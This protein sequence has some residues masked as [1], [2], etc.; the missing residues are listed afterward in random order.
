MDGWI[1]GWIAV[2]M[3]GWP[4]ECMMDGWIDV[5]VGWLDGFVGCMV[6]WFCWI[7]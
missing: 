2:C 3:D 4:D 7:Y 1:D 5:L 6:G